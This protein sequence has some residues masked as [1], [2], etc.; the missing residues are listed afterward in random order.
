MCVCTH[1]YKQREQPFPYTTL[2]C[3][4]LHGTCTIP[5]PF[6]VC[7]THPHLIPSKNSF[8]ASR[9]VAKDTYVNPTA[10]PSINMSYRIGMY[11]HSSAYYAVPRNLLLTDSE[12]SATKQAGCQA[13]HCKKENVKIQKGEIRQ[14]V[15]VTTGEYQSMKWRHW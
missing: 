14:G 9:F 2:T 10:S 7:D 1:K 8:D 5:L 15:L 3:L 13:P 12:I 4:L 11:A 6:H